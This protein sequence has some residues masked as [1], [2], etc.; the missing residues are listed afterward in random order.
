MPVTVEPESNKIIGRLIVVPTPVGNRADITER[1]KRELLAVNL[2][3]CE[4][5]SHSRPFLDYLGVAAPVLSYHEQGDYRRKL[6]KV[7][8]A[9]RNGAR[10]AL[11]TSAGTPGISDPGFAL[12]RACIAEEIPV[13][14][15]PGAT[16]FVPALVISGLPTHRF[17]FE[18]FLPRTGKHTR[19]LEIAAEK[20]TTIIYESPQRLL[21]LLQEL[22][23]YCGADRSGCVVRELSK[24][25][26]EVRRGTLVQ[27]LEHF[28]QKTVKCEIVVLLAG[29]K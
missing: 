3:A 5:P 4:E 6:D 18:G 19:L 17:V 14:C 7:M 12:I 27:L 9:L 21:K 25:F 16:A 22:I 28:S 24:Q 10:V 11:V 13:E 23:E 20:R 8:D 26:E 1:A 29:A 15:L 2:I